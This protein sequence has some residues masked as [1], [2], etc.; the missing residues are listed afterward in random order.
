MFTKTQFVTFRNEFKKSVKN[1]EKEFGIKIELG[2][3][4][5]NESSFRSKITCSKISD[6]GDKVIDLKRFEMLKKRYGFLGN[7]GDSY[8]KGNITY[9]IKDIDSRKPKNCIIISGSNGRN[10]VASAEAANFL[11]KLK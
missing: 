9:T 3:I 10:Y 5:Y 1:L 8:T 4:T 7:Y 2:N 11:L 6:A